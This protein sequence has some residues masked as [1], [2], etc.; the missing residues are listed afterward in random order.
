[1]KIDVSLNFMPAFFVKHTGTKYGEAY[2][3][4]PVYRAQV[5]CVESRFL[6]DCL[7]RYGVGSP[8]PRPSAN[9]F[10]QPVDLIMRTQ[11]A[12][13]RLPDDA[14][15]ESWGNPWANLTPQEIQ[16]ID[17]RA[18]ANHPVVDRILRQYQEMERLY[19]KSADI[20]GIKSGTMNIHTPFTTAHQLCG[21]DLFVLMITEPSVARGIFAK[22][23][24]IYQAIFE[25]IRKATGASPN[26]IQLGDCSAS[27]L[28]EEV[29]RTVVLPVNQA[30]A[31]TFP[32][33]GYHSCGSS[34]H[35]L[36]AF[37]E[38]PRVDA[39]ELGPGTDLRASTAL[40]PKRAMRPLV[41]PRVLREGTPDHVRAL[42]SDILRNTADAPAV[43]LCAWSFDRDTPIPNVAALYETVTGYRE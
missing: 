14:T 10:I 7:G 36:K 12:E 38:L 31:S 19:G 8:T 9:L 24:D 35:L 15:L 29:Y 6:H 23:W 5:E 2:Y 30:I 41:D 39:M 3:F 11:G 18:A 26:R 43:T 13:W 27:L 28:S 40:M 16:R 33:A 34:S 25:R 17:P 42:V 20:F 22:V 21:E 4:D 32:S 1:M 37:V